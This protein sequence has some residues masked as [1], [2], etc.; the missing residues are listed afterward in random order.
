M[1]SLARPASSPAWRAW[2]E[3]LAGA[4]GAERWRL[5]RQLADSPELPGLLAQDHPRLAA[6]AA[7]N[8]RD[9][10]RLAAA[11]LALAGLGGCG[12]APQEEI[13]PMRRAE[14][15]VDQPRFYATVLPF[16]GYGSGV[17]VESHDGRPTKVEGNP[18]H[19]ASLGATDIFSQ[20]AV[21]DL[22]DPDRSQALLRQGAAAGW[23][24][25]LAELGSRS[26]EL[27][28]SQ[29][30]GLR[31]LSGAVTSP[32][33]QAQLAALLQ[34]FP[35]ARH[36]AWQAWPRDNVHQGAA[37]AFGAALEPVYRFDRARV[38]LAL[39]ADFVGAMPGRVRYA[40]D[41]VDGR[42]IAGAAPRMNRLYAAEC[43]PSLSGGMADHC[44]AA[45]MGELG[46]LAR[47]LAAGFGI[48]AGG[49]TPAPDQ[50][51]WIDAVAADLRRH[52]GEALVLAGEAQ[53]PAVHA[54]A[55][56]VNAALAAPGNTVEY[57]EPVAMSAGGIE[58]LVEAMRQEQ[59]EL[60]L[61]LGV[62]PAWDTPADLGFA[63]ALAKVPCSIHLGQYADETAVRSTWHI[64]EAHPLESWSDLRAYDG[65]AAIAQPLL[66]PLYG[67]RSAHELVALLLGRM[68][69]GAHA[70]V[71]E[72]WRQLRPEGFEAFWTQALQQGVVADS[73]APPRHPVLRRYAVAEAARSL[74]PPDPAL[75]LVLRP[76]PT[77][78][79]GRLANN[80]WLQELPKPYSQATWDNAVVVSTALAGS[81]GLRDG[82]EVRLRLD[83]GEV[84]GP[85]WISAR[86]AARSV[87]AFLGYGRSRAGRIGDGLGFD[88]N[89]LR[90]GRALWSAAGLELSPTGRRHELATTQK[91]FRME[92]REPVRSA[93]LE[94]FFADPGVVPRDPREDGPFPSLYPERPPGLHA[95]AMHIDLNVCTG[96]KV[97]TIACQAENNI[98]VV[99]ADQVRRGRAMHWIRVDAY[100]GESGAL[101][102]ALHQPVPCMHCEHAPCELVCPVEAT[103]H[104]SDGLNLQV[105]NRCIGT[106]FCS[107]NCPYKV[108][109]FNF[110][111]YSDTASESLKGQRNPQVTVRNRGVMEKCTYCVQRIRA[112]ELA[113][114]KEQ[115]PVR[116]GEVRTACQAACPTRAISFGDLQDPASDVLKARASPLHYTLLAELNT[117]PRTTY[118]ARL[119]NPNPALL[120]AERQA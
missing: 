98:P 75:E 41:F 112:A 25:F 64:P 110:L 114:E 10:F 74:P 17:L 78:W 59:V 40:R 109:R 77:V 70:L 12:Q 81:L 66:Q 52:P 85:V 56:A 23:N 28:R 39:D 82:D 20:A 32:T 67:G 46:L 99:G 1:S 30:R 88:A 5:L 92:G 15:R 2:R 96:C 45:G 24:T 49:D 71:R 105:Y 73:A 18:R 58:E 65:T 62:N 83:G 33:L 89:R 47:R 22:W 11:S 76:D 57:I 119:R 53:P 104:D 63:A 6:A 61:M 95:W 31:I 8:R 42:R 34:R 117:R 51:Q 68:D 115:R 54:L 69:A 38:I 36:H 50:K 48:D 21:L 14:D 72:H 84:R 102:P 87:T 60:L 103:S 16:D 29:G 44:L 97:C 27:G 90:R 108:R 100:E 93:T 94:Q 86:Q 19:P 80:G 43:T 111:Q 116:D 55:H 79:D 91:H 9:F 107:N 7:L 3:A 118:S 4:R 106:R 37:L 113:A 120:A 26:A 101:A 35:Q 13:V